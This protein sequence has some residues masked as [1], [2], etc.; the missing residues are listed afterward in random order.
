LGGG[1][2]GQRV[3]PDAR[4]ARGARGFERRL[5]ERGSQS[6]PTRAG[7]HVQPLELGHRRWLERSQRHAASGLPATLGQQQRPARRAVRTGQRGE[8]RL[9]VLE[10]E[11]DA[12][13]ISV[14][15]KQRARRREV[16]R[17]VDGT[18]RNHA[19]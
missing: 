1:H 18:N 12:D 8:L 5:G 10:A 11:I 17:R 16:G 13:G 19:R 2:R 4:V 14:L 9:E 15:A 6:S 7:P 3:E